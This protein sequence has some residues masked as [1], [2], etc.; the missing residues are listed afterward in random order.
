MFASCL[1]D[2]LLHRETPNR[3]LGAG[4]CSSVA[5]GPTP[6]LVTHG[7]EDKTTNLIAAE[8]TARMIPGAKLS[9]YEGIGHSPFFEDAPRFNGELTAFVR[10]TRK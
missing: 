3:K 4:G 5:I 10:S 1:P 6:T 7:A 8:Y 9:V 2:S